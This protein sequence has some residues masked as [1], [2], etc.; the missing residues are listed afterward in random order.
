AD[1]P[2]EMNP[3]RRHALAY[4]YRVDGAAH[5]GFAVHLGWGRVIGRRDPDRLRAEYPVGAPVTVHHHPDRPDVAV[6]EPGPSGRVWETLGL[7]G[8]LL[9]A[10]AVLLGAALRRRRLGF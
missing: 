4:A 2:L 10:G 8:V 7:G 5:E 9:A 6:L 1:E 3:V